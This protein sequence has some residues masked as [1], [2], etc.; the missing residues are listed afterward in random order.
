[1]RD[2]RHGDTNP[3]V[4]TQRI[5][6]DGYVLW[7]LSGL[8]ACTAPGFQS[9][10]KIESDGKGG[11]IVVWQDKRT[12]EYDIYMQRISGAG[13][14]LWAEDGLPV[15]D[16]VGDQTYPALVP[17]G[18]G[19]AIIVW[20]DFRDGFEDFYAQRV[21]SNGVKMWAPDGIR[22]CASGSTDIEVSLTS[23]QP[24]ADG[25]GGVI[26]VWADTR[27]VTHYTFAQRI[28]GEG[29][30]LWTEN[31]VRLSS[32]DA[33]LDEGSYTLAVDGFGGAV[34]VWNVEAGFLGAKDDIYAQ[35]IRADGSV[36]WDSAGVG[37]CVSP[38]WW[39]ATPSPIWIDENNI[40]I[41]WTDLRDE[42]G[43]IY[44]QKVDSAGTIQWATNGI[45]VC[46]EP[47][48]QYYP[49]VVRDSD[50][51]IIVTW[52][53]ARTLT[54]DIYSQRV[55]PDGVRLWASEGIEVYH[56][57]G[58]SSLEGVL[59]VTDGNGGGIVSWR[60]PRGDAGCTFA[61]KITNTGDVPVPTF[62][63]EYWADVTGD[64]VML[65]W[66][67]SGSA[68]NEVFVVSRKDPGSHEYL[69][70]QR[71]TAGQNV[72]S[73][74]YV[75]KTCLPGNS[76]VYRVAVEDGLETSVLF[77]TQVLTLP[78]ATL[79]LYQ[80]HP[81]PF[82]PSTVIEYYLPE[83]SFVKLDVYDA[84]GKHVT[85]LIDGYVEPGQRRVLWDGM[86]SEGKQVSSGMYFYR[87]DA[88]KTT[89]SRKMLILR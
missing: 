58:T 52:Q 36:A 48:G 89:L 39:C 50:D 21:D 74:D 85:R 71:I 65:S 53:D 1:W 38:D 69:E 68:E 83:G 77:E 87:L 60:E 24:K 64:W 76:Y 4:Y 41:V 23:P 75:D 72:Y 73:F 88:G 3:D 45:A 70:I 31:G 44:A 42:V 80:N 16:A 46:D 32:N 67:I 30:M 14:V 56:T 40:I 51:G 10:A 84:A 57:V 49:K 47:A 6:G 27:N 34:F 54:Y 66:S 7:G 61:K 62:L 43:H 26:V 28:T 59:M 19:G 12:G 78:P 2:Y 35:R 13:S 81:N 55:S 22:F 25:F 17:D 20:K 86:D 8:S 33:S 11:G 29:E 37:I 79:I 9:N 15:C 63:Q 18:I 82:N 5:N